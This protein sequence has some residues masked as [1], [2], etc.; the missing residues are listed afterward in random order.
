MEDRSGVGAIGEQFCEK[1]KLTEQRGQ[2]PDAAVTILNTSGMNDRVQQHTLHVDENMSF[3][4]FDQFARI[5]PARINAGPPFWP[6][7]PPS[8]GIRRTMMDPI[9]RA[10]A[11]P[12]RKIVMHRAARRKV[13]WDIPPLAAGAQDVHHAVHD[14]PHVDP[15]LT[16]AASRGRDQRLDVCPFVISQVARISQVIAVIPRPVLVRPQWK[17]LL[18][19]RWAPSNPNDS[20][21]SRSLRTDTKTSPIRCTPMMFSRYI[22]RMA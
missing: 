7:A 2:Q 6:L 9:Q 5:E 22:V 10:V 11:K 21:D 14:G 4:A 12:P 16:A 17:P 18:E 8:R 20:K 13:F 15:T 3:L 19:S 1:R